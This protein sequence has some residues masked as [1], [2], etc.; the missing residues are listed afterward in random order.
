[1]ITK[2]LVTKKTLQNMAFKAIKSAEEKRKGIYE[3]TKHSWLNQMV[4]TKW[5]QVGIGDA[6]LKIEGEGDIDSRMKT[7]SNSKDLLEDKITIDE[8]LDPGFRDYPLHQV[9]REST[10]SQI[11]KENGDYA[12]M[13]R[14]PIPQS[15][16]DHYASTHEFQDILKY[17]S[18]KVRKCA[19]KLD[20]NLKKKG[21]VFRKI[22]K[23]VL[24]RIIAKL[25]ENGVNTNI[26]LEL[27]PRIGKTILFLA[28]ARHYKETHQAMFVKAYGVG[29]SVKISYE[30]E[31]NTWSEFD[32]FKFIDASFDNAEQLYNEAISKGKMPIVFVSLNPE[33]Y[34]KKYKWIHNITD[35]IISLLEETDFGVWTE[36][37]V[38]K[39]AYLIANKDVTRINSSG[40]NIGKI[41]KAMGDDSIDDVISV[42][43]CMVENDNS[44]KDRVFRKFY[45]VTFSAKINKLL[46][47]YDIEDLPN[48]RKILEKPYAQRQFLEA[49][50]KDLYGYET[51]Y[52]L[53]ID[54]QAEE[55][56]RTSM[57]FVNN[58]KT[59][60]NQLA[61]LIE[62][63]CT[64][65]KV[66]VL[67][68]DTKGMNNKKAEGITNE[69]L[70]ELKTGVHQ[71]RDK[72]II[73]TNMMG[74]RSYTISEIQAS[75]FLQEG[76]DL[77]PFNQ[78][79]SRSL[80]P[81]TDANGNILKKFGHIFM[82]GFD[83]NKTKQYELA[84]GVEASQVA[85]LTG[86]SLPDSIRQVLN[87]VAMKDVLS[88]EWL[89]ANDIIKKFEDCNKLLEVA[90]AGTKIT[91]ED[92]TQD[93]LEAFGELAKGFTTSK[94]GRTNIDKTVKTGK[95][96]NSTSTSKSSKKKDPLLVIVE[97]AIRRLNSSASTIIAMTNYK[98]KGF[99]GCLNTIKESKELS[100][101]FIELYGVDVD[102]VLRLSSRLPI[103]TLDMIIHNTKNGVTNKQILN[104]SLGIVADDLDLWRKILNTRAI[105]RKLKS[106]KCKKILVCA[107][108]FG[109]EIDVLVEMFSVD[110]T[111]KIVYNDKYTHN[112]NDIKRRYPNITVIKG[113]FLELEFDMK[114]NASVGNYPYPDPDDS[115]GTKWLEFANKV[116][117]LLEPNGVSAAIH[118]PSFIGKHLSKG[119]GKSDY[120]VFKENQINEIHLFDDAKKEKY[121][122]GVG[123]KICWY[124]G[125]K[126]SPTTTKIVGYSKGETYEFDV[127]FT[128]QGILP[129]IVN[130][131]SMSIHNKIV[132]KKSLEFIQTRELH[133]Y[134]MKQ[135]NQVSEDVNSDYPYKS[136]FSHAIKRASN[137]KMRDYHNVKIMVPQTSTFKNSFVDKDCNVSEDL[138]YIKSNSTEA[139]EL[140]EYLQSDLISYIGK[141]YRQGRNLGGMLNSGVIPIKDSGINFTQEE[142]DYIEANS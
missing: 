34:K 4:H 101:E 19:G 120:T 130:P 58:N 69:M 93:E 36:S 140:L 74:S 137:F 80:S 37:Q 136:Y 111:K 31:I 18:K 107:G 70:I 134:S 102:T 13:F 14:F 54:Q 115:G 83:T 52:G 125:T 30:T 21:V 29:L 2:E 78:K 41:A 113:N 51:I 127:D 35:P 96:Y 95:T 5:L 59:A 108:G 87:S 39:I 139:T 131:L 121:F 73:L 17:V 84:I 135:K 114:F 65:H 86:K 28:L 71:G 106:N 109:T 56:I 24:N 23:E 60:M 49:L 104:S 40:T 133:Y 117:S 72:L 42:P 1:V 122:P 12:E 47:N 124:I 20:S 6:G 100:K 110:L 44:I 27:A 10:A 46:E 126:T 82:F 55:E 142:R 97:R 128:K 138:Y 129:Q 116:F 9:I 75:L 11:K 67:N 103:P 98:G 38:K 90:N 77:F 89:D 53:S 105:R 68:S 118:P 45:D 99:L 3:I 62:K 81:W 92:L 57:I 63:C 112:C 91:L 32:C 50:F 132:S 76:G 88:G 61:K 141:H 25:L 33:D 48:I 26:V 64:E 94:K 7:L 66:L 8:F 43:Y 16:I 15:M 123:T 22:Q 79:Y 119:T 85:K